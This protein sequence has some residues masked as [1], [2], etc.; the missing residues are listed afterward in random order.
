MSC[1]RQR[2]GRPA[3]PR[4]DDYS[5]RAFLRMVV[6]ALG[7]M[8]L[9]FDVAA[10]VDAAADAHLARESPGLPT[11]LFLTQAELAD[12]DAIAAQ[13]IPTD[14]TPGAREAG[15]ALFI[16][17]ELATFF[18]RLAPDFCSELTAFRQRCP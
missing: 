18:A 14:D 15:A 5:R 10:I 9:T 17:R 3:A 8:G 6:G 1:T 16:D 4:D 13:I 2:L 7:G 11:P 12:V